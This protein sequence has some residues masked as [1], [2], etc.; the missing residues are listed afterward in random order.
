MVTRYKIL[1]NPRSLKANLIL[2]SFTELWLATKN[3]ETLVGKSCNLQ[4]QL[5][6]FNSSRY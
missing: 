5:W 4:K 6:I 1:E 3:K 2:K